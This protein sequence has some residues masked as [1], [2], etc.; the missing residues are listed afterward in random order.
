[1]AASSI[2]ATNADTDSA[3]ILTSPRR[4]RGSVAYANAIA[5]VVT[6]DTGSPA[7]ACRATVTA[8]SVTA[9]ADRRSNRRSRVQNTYG[10]VAIDHDM[11]G[12]FV[13]ETIGPDKPNAMPPSAAATGVTCFLRNRYIPIAASGTGSATHVLK[14]ITSDG[15]SRSSSEGR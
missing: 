15:S 9:T 11:L 10:T 4:G 5:S 12:K 6:S 1:M 14:A 7:S 8:T 2:P 13:D 3:N